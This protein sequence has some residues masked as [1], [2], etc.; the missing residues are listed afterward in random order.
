M[1]CARAD[2]TT[3]GAVPTRILT[4]WGDQD[5]VTYHG[6]NF[7]KG[8]VI[9]YG[10]VEN[11]NVDPIFKIASDPGVSSFDVRLVRSTVGK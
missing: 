10:A 7:A 6:A 4:A 2:E 1:R 5:T 3:I 11:S 8:Q 9:M